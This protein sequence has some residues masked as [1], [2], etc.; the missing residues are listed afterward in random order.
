MHNGQLKKEIMYD[1]QIWYAHF[2]NLD[3]F[4]FADKWKPETDFVFGELRKLEWTIRKILSVNTH[5]PRDET[6]IE[7]NSVLLK[8]GYHA[9]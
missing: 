3:I 6:G 8:T 2:G 4:Y 7:E 1:A 9:E 5:T